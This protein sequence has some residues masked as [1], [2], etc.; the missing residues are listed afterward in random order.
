M[1]ERETITISET[2]Y[3]VDE[4]T[5][6]GRRLIQSLKFVD[7][8]IGRLQNKI[9]VLNTAKAAYLASLKPELPSPSKDETIQ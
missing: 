6:E 2:E 8:E 5:E 9:A 1:S 3:F 7:Q 4:L